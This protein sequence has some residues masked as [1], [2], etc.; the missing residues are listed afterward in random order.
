MQSVRAPR[1]DTKA[2][3]GEERPHSGDETAKEG[4][5]RRPDDCKW[6]NREEK[7]SPKSTEQQLTCLLLNSRSLLNKMDFLRS[8]TC[9]HDPDIVGVTESWANDKVSDKELEISGYDLFRMDRSI[10]MGVEF[11]STLGR[12]CRQVSSRY[13]RPFRK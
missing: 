11:F 10:E 6:N 8:W 4:W 7:K 2:E 5:R 9:V 1:P 12:L 3:R 13:K